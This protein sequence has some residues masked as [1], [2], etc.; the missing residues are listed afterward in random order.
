MT[1]D[2]LAKRHSVRSYSTRP[3]SDSDKSRV[4]A[5]VTAVNT[6]EAGL[7]FVLVTDSPEAFAGLGRSYGI[8]KGVRNYIALVI[9]SSAYIYMEEKAGYYAQM[10]VMKCVEM[11]LGTCFV[12]GTFSRKHLDVQLRAG[13]S[14]PA[15]I[16]LGYPEES[17]QK[18][19]VMARIAHKIIKRKSKAPLQFYSGE[20]P[21]E[22]VEKEFPLMLEALKSV[23][24]A[25]S[26]LN[27]QPVSIL[28]SRSNKVEKTDDL[29]EDAGRYERQFKQVE[30]E[31]R[32]F[33]LSPVNSAMQPALDFEGDFMIEAYVP[34]QSQ[35][36][37]LG[38][39]MWNFEQIF[40]GYWEWGNPARFIPEI[41]E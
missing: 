37:D 10:L 5:A 22:D 24:L 2:Q 3:L 8:F 12:G 38:I 16:T 1:L 26:S 11:G 4:R 17:E 41:T 9:D 34:K 21:W 28:V 39:A 20:L 31:A 30:A 6:H 23:S 14:V 7:H 19:G 29:T 35:L 18:V 25:P 32:R 13:W 36:I 27:K 15:V 40:P 33:L